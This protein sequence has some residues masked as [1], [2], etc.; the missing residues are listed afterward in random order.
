MVEPTVREMVEIGHL[1]G[2]PS[3][4]IGISNTSGTSPEAATLQLSQE[5]TD[6]EYNGRFN[7]MKELEEENNRLFIEAYGC[8]TSLLPKYRTSK[9]LFTVLTVPRTR[10]GCSPTPSA[11]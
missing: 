1:I 4:L 5:A 10:S 8:K 7:K 6:S 2:T 9:S 11:A 3:R